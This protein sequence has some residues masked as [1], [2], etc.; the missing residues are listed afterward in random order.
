[1][2]TLA[3]KPGFDWRRVR[4]GAPDA[5]RTDRCSYCG[6]KLPDDDDDDAEPFVPLILWNREGWCA[7]FCA[8]CQV[9]WWGL[10]L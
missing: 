7:E 10:T 3:P 8:G 4:W 6:A 2:T 9:K 1:M 5:R